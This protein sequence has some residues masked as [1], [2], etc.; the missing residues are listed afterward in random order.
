M[1]TTSA[2]F[3][4]A[5]GAYP[6]EVQVEPPVEQNRL[7][8]LLRIIFAIPHAIIISALGYVV[9]VTAFIAWLIILFTGKCPPGLLK[10][11]AGYVR[12][13]ARAY[14][15]LG[16]LT[17]K[18]PPF[19]LD[20]DPA[21]P[22]RVSVAEAAEGRNRLTVFFRVILAIPHLIVLSIL[23]L[24]VYIVAFIA[25]IIAL[26]TGVVPEGMHNFIG[27]VLRWSTRV[28]AYLY[29]LRDEYPPFSLQ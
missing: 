29:L 1:T 9:G 21:Y 7:S 5:G 15:Y 17:D 27:G 26:I 14:G 12:W 6:V 10:F 24:V 22:I 28:N 20:D 2:E 3:A 13:A 16:L 19:S 4:M 18:Y 8:V 25:W 23:G 11:H